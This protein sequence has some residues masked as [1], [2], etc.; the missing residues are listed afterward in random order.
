M[1]W[2]LL[3]EILP[4]KNELSFKVCWKEESKKPV[5]PLMKYMQI[6]I[7]KTRNLEEV[8]CKTHLMSFVFQAH[9][10]NKNIQKSV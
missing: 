10:L 2:Q 5:R 7:L 3:I 8:S 1:K 9:A 4:N 6:K